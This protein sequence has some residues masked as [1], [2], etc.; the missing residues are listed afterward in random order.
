MDCFFFHTFEWLFNVRLMATMKVIP[1]DNFIVVCDL[2]S[3]F[4]KQISS[5]VFD[6]LKEHELWEFVEKG[7]K[8]YL[9]S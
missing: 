2:V 8:K 1:L 4:L 9:C 5:S 7:V 3:L 6:S